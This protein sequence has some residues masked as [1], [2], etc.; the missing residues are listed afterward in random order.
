MTEGV[1]HQFYYLL[2]G[3]EIIHNQASKRNITA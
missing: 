1:A 2:D 3:Y